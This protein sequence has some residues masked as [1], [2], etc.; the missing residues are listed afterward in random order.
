VTP[1][2]VAVGSGAA[3]VQVTGTNFG[4]ST[5]VQLGDNAI[6]TRVVSSTRL[7]ATVDG[8][9]ITQPGTHS[10]R[11]VNPGPK[12]GSSE[13]ATFEVRTPQPRITGLDSATIAAGGNA[14]SVRVLGEGFYQ[15]PW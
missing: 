7:E 11:V 3:T 5:Y 14:Q 13:A 2:F 8:L 10:L 4:S 15:E 6:P 9:T 1:S 12:G